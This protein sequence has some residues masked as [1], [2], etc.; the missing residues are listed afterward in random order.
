MEKPFYHRCVFVPFTY[1]HEPHSNFVPKPNIDAESL[2][3]MSNDLFAQ[4]SNWIE[5]KF[6]ILPHE[7]FKYALKRTNWLIDFIN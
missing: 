3:N 1:Q 5:K 7:T 4:S 2:N 6:V